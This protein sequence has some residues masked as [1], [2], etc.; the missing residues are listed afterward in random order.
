MKKILLGVGIVIL[1]TIG[2]ITYVVAKDT[3]TPVKTPSAASKQVTKPKPPTVNELLKLV[4]AERKKVGVAPLV[5]D[6]RLNESAQRKSDEM[7][8][9]KRLE[10]T[11]K[12]G[13]H[14]YTYIPRNVG[15]I[16]RSENWVS[17]LDSEAAMD[18]WM[19]S[20]LHKAAIQNKKYDL[21][22]IGITKSPD[23]YIIVEHFCDLPN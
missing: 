6:E 2:G 1:A 18:W 3:T 19:R 21:T 10:H 11:N 9:E 5:L 7:V 22:G 4:N 15:C 23:W 17:A 14:G 13:V 20:K 16:Y 12:A 8:A